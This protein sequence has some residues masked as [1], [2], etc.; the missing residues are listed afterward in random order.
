MWDNGR[1]AGSTA[2]VLGSLALALLVAGCSE[3]SAMPSPSAA[4]AS[5][6]SAIARK[7]LLL[8]YNPVLE[9]RGGQRLIYQEGW[10][11]PDTLTT[12]YV[13]DIN[14]AS[15]GVARYVQAGRVELDEYPVSEDG[16]QYTD[17]TFVACLEDQTRASCHKPGMD[18]GF[19]YAIDYA[20]TL[21]KNR[22]CER[23]NAGEFDELWMF[24]APFMGFW[25]TNQAGSRAIRTN[26][27]IVSDSSCRGRLNIM[28][29]SYERGV[30]EMLEDFGHR[31]EGT[32]RTLLP[33]WE[34][35]FEQ[36][37][38]Y[39][40]ANPDQ[41]QCGTVH[42]APNSTAA[43]DWTNPRHV[44]SSCED[45][46]NY[47]NRTGATQSMN[48]TAWNCD[49]RQHKIWWLTHFPHVTGVATDG[50]SNNWWSYLL[51]TGR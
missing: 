40:H 21:Q 1:H 48:C 6:A 35:L 27:P 15:H 29:F 14:Q 8:I 47:P 20:T 12:Q 3:V 7:Y 5:S 10:N 19:G 38:R 46:L 36:F 18:A 34:K 26:G 32:L 31:S 28:G 50:S 43:Y 17:A 13:A 51:S 37:T 24:G 41:A 2:G 22:I 49:G 9:I 11:S 25:E 45:W 42:F 33:N 16:F 23:F 44:Q 4:P 39:D 30:A